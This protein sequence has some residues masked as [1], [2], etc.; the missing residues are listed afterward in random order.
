MNS[1]MRAT[2]DHLKLLIRR[3]G[4]TRQTHKADEA[5]VDALC[6]LSEV[7]RAVEGIDDDEEPSDHHEPG[8]PGCAIDRVCVHGNP[9]GGQCLY[10]DGKNGQPAIR[11]CSCPNDCPTHGR[12][13]RAE[14]RKGRRVRY[15]YQ[16]DPIERARRLDSRG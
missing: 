1:Q 2:L 16:E 6:H 4:Y 10:C 8:Y 12:L 14:L 3:E 11:S 7:E 15:P 5:M 13:D 9:W